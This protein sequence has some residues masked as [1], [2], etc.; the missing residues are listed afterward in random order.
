MYIGAHV[1]SSNGGK[2]ATTYV[3]MYAWVDGWTNAYMC[4]VCFCLLVQVYMST[5][6]YVFSSIDFSVELYMLPY[7]YACVCIYIHTYLYMYPHALDWRR[8]RAQLC[9]NLRF[10]CM[11]ISEVICARYTRR[12]I[13]LSMPYEHVLYQKPKLTE[14]PRLTAPSAVLDTLYARVLTHQRS[15]ITSA[16]RQ[17]RSHSS[18]R[19]P[20]TSDPYPR[21][22]TWALLELHSRT[23]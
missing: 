5:H 6:T 13:G 19:T 20:G 12:P 1:G 16:V 7:M 14:Q 21:D 9:M 15:G 2:R 8:R 23:S 11:L 10:C 4:L 3:S 22:V 18:G 17:S